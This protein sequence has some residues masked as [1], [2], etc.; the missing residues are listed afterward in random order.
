MNITHPKLHKQEHITKVKTRN[1]AWLVHGHA[2]SN[3]LPL[4]F[5]APPGLNN[6]TLSFY[7]SQNSPDRSP[8]PRTFFH[9][10]NCQNAQNDLKKIQHLLTFNKSSKKAS[11]TT[12]AA[13][14]KLQ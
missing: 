10:T 11:Q 14:H 12:V 5:L 1:K 8:D 3:H 7:D 6:T 9:T 13:V 2:S 4:A